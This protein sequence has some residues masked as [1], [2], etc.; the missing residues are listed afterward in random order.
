MHFGD[1]ITSRVVISGAL[2]LLLLAHVNAGH[3]QEPVSNET[4]AATLR[5]LGE[6]A[7]DGGRN[8]V[9]RD[10]FAHAHALVPDARALSGYGQIY[11]QLQDYEKA[12][13]WWRR[14]LEVNPNMVGVEMNIRGAEQLLKERRGRST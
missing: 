13:A 1:S 7:L 3:A 2:A 12:I 4:Q 8:E 9:A 14:A 11:F 5:T 10:V 6:A